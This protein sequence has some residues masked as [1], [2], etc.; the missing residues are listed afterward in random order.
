[1][2]VIKFGGTS[3]KN[4]LRFNTALTKIKTLKKKYKTLI[5]VVSAPSGFTDL[6][7][8]FFKKRDKNVDSILT[9]GE[10][11]SSSFLCFILNKN[12]I[13]ALALQAWQIPII[14]KGKSNYKIDYLN[15][16]IFKKKYSVF[17]VSGF[18]SL[19]KRN[20]LNTLQRGG[21][22][23][24]AI[25]IS[26]FFKKKLCFI[27]TDVKGVYQIDPRIFKSKLIKKI[28]PI[29]ILEISSLGAKV[30]SLESLR[31]SIK[32]KI[33]IRVL[34]SFKKNKLEKEIKSGTLINMKNFKTNCFF[35]KQDELL[36][37]VK[38]RELYIIV[39]KFCKIGKNIDMLSLNKNNYYLS[40]KKED[41]IFL[42]LNL[43]IKKVIKISFVGLKI[44][45]R[46]NFYK[47]LKFID[48]FSYKKIFHFT[49]IKL[50][51]LIKKDNFNK[52]LDF[53]NKKIRRCGRED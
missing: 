15:K 53:F 27:Y 5:I 36:I 33:C 14:S 41:L 48:K 23:T 9:L 52:C 22:D 43:K 17:I 45:E 40:I 44:K 4:L 31:Y 2:L 11:F 34:S 25:F 16:K 35:V 49:E 26:K 19:N 29:I 20:F 39:K 12:K 13:K 21:S 6:F 10:N 46:Y 32:N 7:L 18:Q 51:F 30:L 8:N 1:M 50:S 47:I 37:K 42:S 28:N 24:T 38:K 3:L